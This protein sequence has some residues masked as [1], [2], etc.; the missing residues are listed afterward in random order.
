M[1]TLASD[2]LIQVLMLIALVL[3]FLECVNRFVA[4][5]I[6]AERRAIADNLRMF[7]ESARAEHFEL[8]PDHIDGLADNIEEGVE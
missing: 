2:P 6:D 3:L 8:V 5:A 4:T 1:A 7:A